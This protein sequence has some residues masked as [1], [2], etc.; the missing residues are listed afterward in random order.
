MFSHVEKLGSIRHTVV[1][2]PHYSPN[3]YDC[4]LHLSAT[5][6]SIF[7]LFLLRRVIGLKPLTVTFNHQACMSNLERLQLEQALERLDVDNIRFNARKSIRTRLEQDH[8]SDFLALVVKA[9]MTWFALSCAKMYR[10]PLVVFDVAMI[11]PFE[12][13]MDAA[14]NCFHA[15]QPR[16]I[17]YLKKALRLEILQS[18]GLDSLDLKPYRFD[19]LEIESV[20]VAKL[21]DFFGTLTDAERRCFDQEFPSID[22]ASPS[23]K[24]G[25]STQKWH[26]REG[27]RKVTSELRAGRPLTEY[28]HLASVSPVG[29]PIFEKTLQYCTRCCLPE[30]AEGI[31]FD[32][33]GLCQP[34]RSSEQKMHIN[35]VERE[36]WLRS[37]L[38]EHRCTDKS[39]Y[40]VIVPISGGKDSTF[41][42]YVLTQNYNLRPLAVTFNHSW[43][44][45]TGRRNLDNACERFDVDHVIFTPRR[46]VINKLARKSLF[47][48][49]D[50]CWHCHAGV[51]SFPL[52]AASRFTVRLLVWGE[53][54]SERDGRATYDTPIRF[55]REYFT[56]ISARFYA[57]QMVDEN[58]SLLDVKPYILPSREELSATG[59]RGIHL[60][61]Y[62]FWDDERQTEFVRDYWGWLEDNVEGAYKGYKSVECRMAGVHDYSKFIKRGFG[63]G[64]DQ[65]SLDV[66][67]GLMTR[68][69]GLEIAKKYDTE[70]PEALDYYL[71][72]SGYTEKEFERILKEKRD[73]ASRKLP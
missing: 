11:S 14:S 35:W 71:R 12:E 65:A 47:M 67:A 68:E 60:G 33:M 34:C 55:D 2:S 38:N 7:Q 51:G 57:E 44:S 42:L 3:E 22:A 39:N 13:E 53:S 29:S 6:S 4:I 15:L 23:S 52:L 50:S 5:P 32:E 41:Q 8:H 66:R 21:C 70:R 1:N 46:S 10:I 24:N 19:Q 37:I 27:R 48:I 20:Q 72:E 59:V 30:T 62:I 63:R 49:G 61:D 45:E 17:E 69:E 64:T 18:L 73:A 9:G 25:L 28:E 31:V 58:I 43:Y 26:E 54:V 40:D 56:K 36:R 16:H